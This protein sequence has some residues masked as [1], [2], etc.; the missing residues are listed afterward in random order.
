MK[1]EFWRKPPETFFDQVGSLPFEFADKRD[2]MEHITELAPKKARGRPRKRKYSEIEEDPDPEDDLDEDWV[3]PNKEH[4]KKPPK[5]RRRV[6]SDKARY[7]V[8]IL[9]P[10]AFTHFKHFKIAKGDKKSFKPMKRFKK[11]TCDDMT[12][13]E[14][15]TIR[16]QL[17]EDM[18]AEMVV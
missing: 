15:R 11:Q 8:S 9:Y 14:V 13:S 16:D 6:E 5:K 12:E 3:P 7:Q 1:Q 4:C 17:I 10:R 18:N 2:R